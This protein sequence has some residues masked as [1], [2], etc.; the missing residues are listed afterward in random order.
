MIE[1]NEKERMCCGRG[2]QRSDRM[3]PEKMR[4]KK[5]A[6]RRESLRAF[7]IFLENDHPENALFLGEQ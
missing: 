7:L 4:S 6:R 5:E 2:W 3:K 1:V